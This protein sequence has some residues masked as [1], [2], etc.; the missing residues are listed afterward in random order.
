MIYYTHVHYEGTDFALHP[1]D[2]QY[3]KDAYS[4]AQKKLSPVELEKFKNH[5]MVR[6]GIIPKY[7]YVCIIY[8]LYMYIFFVFEFSSVH[9]HVQQMEY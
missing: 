5:V 4:D 6:R 1:E 8:V 7:I 3:L 9:A 2:P